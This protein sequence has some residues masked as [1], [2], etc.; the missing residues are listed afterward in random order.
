MSYFESRP[1]SNRPRPG[2]DSCARDLLATPLMYLALADTVVLAHFAFVLFVVLGGL[3]A[4]RWRRVAWVHLP[5][6]TWGVLIEFWGGICPLTPL[7]NSLRERAGDIAYVNTFIEHY[8][9]P[10]LYPAMLTR[11]AQL[12]IGMFVLGVNAGVYWRVIHRPG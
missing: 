11:N 12:V 9:V 7:E 1:H 6:A 10:A 4:L 2:L 3:L 5:A 8:V